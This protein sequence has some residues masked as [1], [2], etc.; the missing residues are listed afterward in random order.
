M[1]EPTM[2]ELPLN[3][4]F[5]RY[6]SKKLNIAE[7]EVVDVYQNLNKLPLIS[8]YLKLYSDFFRVNIVYN[9][10]GIPVSIYNP[11]ARFNLESTLF[12]EE[13]AKDFVQ[14]KID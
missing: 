8:D 4:D 3:D 11:S 1:H 9:R 6:A 13:S 2:H 7:E 5:I 14:G 12:I 10:P